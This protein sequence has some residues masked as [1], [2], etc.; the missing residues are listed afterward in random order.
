METSQAAPLGDEILLERVLGGETEAFSGL[1]ERYQGP[2][3]SFLNRMLRDPEAARDVAQDAFVKAFQSL[4]GYVGRN[5][6]AFSTWLFAIARNR[7]LDLL[8]SSKRRATEDLD[9]HAH[10]PAPDA[11][12]PVRRLR[13]RTLLEE[14]L[15]GMNPDQRMAFELTV[16]QGFSYEEAAVILGSN[17]GTIRSR[18]SRA[19]E[20]LQ[21]KLRGLAG[22]G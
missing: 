14:G 7:C 6:A 18:V 9:D 4:D 20:Q 17:S 1:V 5:Q 15:E 21:G 12:D 10:L 3:I 16:A 8:R 11:G 19:R 13:I 22:K 2:L